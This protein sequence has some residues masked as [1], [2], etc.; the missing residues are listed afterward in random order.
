MNSIR[1][2]LLRISSVFAIIGFIDSLYLTTVHYINV[3]PVCNITTRC[4]MILTSRFSSIG[5]IPLALIGV[6]YYLTLTTFSVYLIFD[7][8]KLLFRIL[9]AII[10]LGFIVSISLVSIQAFVLNAF[11]QYCLISEATSTILFFLALKIKRT[12]NRLTKVS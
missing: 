3:A 7:F 4:E 11:C 5:P 1:N 10:S 2:N 8:D 12:E 6:F 9:F